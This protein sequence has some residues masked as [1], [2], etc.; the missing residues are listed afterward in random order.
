MKDETPYQDTE[1]TEATRVSLI[2]GLGNPGARYAGTRHNAGF[3]VVDRLYERF[4]KGQ[5]QL[6]RHGHVAQVTGFDRDV[7]LLKPQTFM[8]SSG[9]AVMETVQILDLQSV[10]VLL[11]YDCVDLPLGRIRLRQHGSSGGHRGVESVIA[12]LG[13]QEFPRLRVGIGRPGSETI[14]YV[15]SSWAFAEM[16]LVTAVLDAA[17]D[18]VVHVLQH[19]V[20]SA[21]NAYNGWSADN[22]DTEKTRGE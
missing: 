15:L 7:R 13:T 1:R 20:Q 14:D 2:V 18:A 4:G 19:G 11:V 12:T 6:T 5:W 22:I 3:L 8:N 21:M 10:E 9:L 16:P 17:V